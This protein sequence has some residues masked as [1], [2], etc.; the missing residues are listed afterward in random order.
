MP[1]AE[2][3]LDAIGT[4]AMTIGRLHEEAGSAGCGKPPWDN[5]VADLDLVPVPAGKLEGISCVTWSSLCPCPVSHG[6]CGGE[7]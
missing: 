5:Q 6:L 1:V 2:V 7:H 3:G 4:A